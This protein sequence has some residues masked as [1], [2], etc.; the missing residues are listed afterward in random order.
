MRLGTPGKKPYGPT[1]TALGMLHPAHLRH[2]YS[3]VWLYNNDVATR[4]FD[5]ATA[6]E[7]WIAVRV[8]SALISCK[9]LQRACTGLGTY[10][11]NEKEDW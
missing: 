1:C 11:L 7:V 5:Q 8:E 10:A 2:A 4:C 6:I 9:S 3:V